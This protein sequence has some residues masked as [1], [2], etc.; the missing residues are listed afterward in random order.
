LVINK[1]DTGLTRLDE[2]ANLRKVAPFLHL[3]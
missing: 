1:E 3:G 2:L